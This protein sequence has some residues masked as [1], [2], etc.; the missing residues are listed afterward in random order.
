MSLYARVAVSFRMSSTTCLR[1]HDSSPSI[2]SDV[3]T[4]RLGDIQARLLDVGSHVATPRDNAAEGKLTRT[5]CDDSWT[6]SLEVFVSS[7][8]LARIGTNILFDTLS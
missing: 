4:G 5:R 3:L 2:I 6:T 7:P 8:T 1:V